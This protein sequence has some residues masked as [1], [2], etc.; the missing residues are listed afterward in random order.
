MRATFALILRLVIFLTLPAVAG[1]WVLA[2]P[3]VRM[4]FEHGE[5][6]PRSTGLVVFALHFYALGLIGHAVVEIAERVFYAM[7]DTWAPVLV[8]VGAMALNVVLSLVWVGRWQHGGLA[9][10]N[11]VATSLE[12]L[13]LLAL[14][15]R[16]MGGLELGELGRS[17]LRNGIASGLMALLVWRASERWQESSP[18]GEVATVWLA[19]LGGIALAAASYGVLAL[20]LRS[21]EARWL[22]GVLL[23]RDRAAG[24]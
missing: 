11:S 24:S 15:H 22:A 5:F 19:A 8:G 9:L 7:H 6:D 1:L 23:R 20:L 21:G 18:L 13:W 16:R 4:L 3:M 14:L 12:M 10:A 2:T 17:L